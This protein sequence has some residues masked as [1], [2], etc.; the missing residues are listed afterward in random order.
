MRKR[1]AFRMYSPALPKMASTRERI[2]PGIPAG[3]RLFIFKGEKINSGWRKMVKSPKKSPRK[4]SG[5]RRK[6]ASPKKSSPVKQ[7]YCDCVV[8]VGAKEK[9][10]SPYAVCS[11]SVYGSR[12][13]KGPGKTECFMD[14]DF[15][16]FNLPELRSIFKSKGFSTTGLS[17]SHLLY[18][19]EEARNAKRHDKSLSI[20][21]AFAMFL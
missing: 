7:K 21:D 3:S 6:I 14:Y 2:R 9:V 5:T 13:L 19:L 16:K 4:G 18:I 1:D 10:K 17:K 20:E 8:K 15:E 11:K 12:G